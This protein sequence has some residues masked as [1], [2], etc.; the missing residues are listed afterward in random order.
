MAKASGVARVEI[1][2]QRSQPIIAVYFGIGPVEQ[3]KYLSRRIRREPM[4]RWLETNKSSDK[5]HRL[6][7]ADMCVRIVPMLL[8][9]GANS[10][11]DADMRLWLIPM[12]D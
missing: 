12:W 2:C 11:L 5:P 4:C 9:E 8:R 7:R 3:N 10:D 6:R 1:G